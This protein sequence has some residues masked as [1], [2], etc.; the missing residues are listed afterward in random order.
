MNIYNLYNGKRAAFANHIKTWWF[1]HKTEDLKS[2][3]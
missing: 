3:L 1:T 2:A